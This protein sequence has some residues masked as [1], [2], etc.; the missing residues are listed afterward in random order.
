M[1]F[2]IR[3]RAMMCWEDLESKKYEVYYGIAFKNKKK[4]VVKKKK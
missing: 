4:K 1:I 3:E 2:R